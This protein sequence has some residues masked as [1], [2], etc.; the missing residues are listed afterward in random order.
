MKIVMSKKT[1]PIIPYDDT[2][3]TSIDIPFLFFV[4]NLK[5]KGN[6][7]ANLLH[8]VMKKKYVFEATFIDSSKS[9]TSTYHKKNS[10]IIISLTCK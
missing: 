9:S 10:E 7:Q 2:K 6:K 1:F 5:Y 3:L 8:N 4:D